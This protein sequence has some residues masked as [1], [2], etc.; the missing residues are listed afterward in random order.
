MDTIIRQASLD[1]KF[2]IFEF[3][4]L[5][6]GD[7]SR[8]KIPGRWNWQ[9]FENPLVDKNGKKLPIFIAIKDGHI[10]GQLCAV[11]SQIKIGEEICQVA[12]SCDLVVLP[13]CRGE[14]IGQRLI[15]ALAEYYKIYYTISC[16]GTTRRIF[17]RIEHLGYYK[18]EPIPTYRRL[19][20]VNKDSVFYFIMLKTQ[21]YL[22]LNRIAMIGCSIGLD[23]V[24]YKTAN[25]LIRIRDL[26][27]RK[28]KKE[29]SSE[30]REI[31]R[32][33]ND[34]DSLWKRTNH[35]FR[36]IVKRDQQFLNWRFSDNN[37]LNYRKFI[38]R[39]DG[40]TRGYIVVRMPDPTELDVGIIVDLYADPDDNETIK[41]LVRHA[42]EFFDKNVKVIECPINQKNF[43][44]ILLKLGFFK[45][46]KTEPI[47]FCLDSRLRTKLEKW[48]NRW[49]ITKAD[50]D[51]D[52]LRP[53]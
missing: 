47:F 11:L 18:F 53:I 32:F 19:V 43:Q 45:M 1:D 21:K 38:N 16:S 5:A 49:Y 44:R 23:I 40:E 48:K 29:Y 24:I 35:K 34:I 9:F 10:A 42:I 3:I 39:R 4:N 15:Q 28:T 14:G 50:Q 27:E 13:E 8:N 30:I 52:Q 20:K 26:F 36:V 33:G 25:L 22:W 31:E 17:D 51:W 37:H 6:Y 2:E 12:A 41:D 46:E 7:L